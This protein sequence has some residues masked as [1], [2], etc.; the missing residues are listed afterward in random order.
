M[1]MHMYKHMH[2]LHILQLVHVGLLCEAR[3]RERS[4]LTM[5]KRA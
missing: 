3:E 1:H 4:V 2:T 5:T